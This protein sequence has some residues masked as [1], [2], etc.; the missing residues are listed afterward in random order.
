MLEDVAQ[1]EPTSGLDST[2]SRLVV[3]ALQ[4]VSQLTLQPCIHSTQLQQFS[5]AANPSRTQTVSPH[6]PDWQQRTAEP[7]L[8]SSVT[9]QPHQ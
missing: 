7:V 8:V 6:M 3:R 2:S 4:E 1:D 5:P 9:S